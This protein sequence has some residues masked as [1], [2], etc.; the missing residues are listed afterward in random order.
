MGSRAI[1][2][3]DAAALISEAI[4]RPVRHCALSAVALTRRLEQLGLPSDYA[5]VLAGMDAEIAQGAGDR[6][7]GGAPGTL[8]AFLDARRAM[9]T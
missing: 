9:F 8:E 3:D 7:T 6:V 4:G 2:Y 5:A 1:S